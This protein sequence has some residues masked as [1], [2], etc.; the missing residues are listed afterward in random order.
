LAKAGVDV[1]LLERGEFPGAKNLFGG[2]LYSSV[3]Q[4]IVPR[5]WEEAPLER[6]I[7][8]RELTMLTEETA[9]SVAVNCQS[10]SRPPYN[11]FTILRS[12]FDR[13]FAQKA[14]EA[15]ARLVNNVTVDD[16]LVQ[17][18]R[19]TGVRT[20]RA[21]G[22]LSAKVVV[23]ADGANSFLALQA[24][25]RRQ[26]DPH[27]MVVGVKEVF[28]L[29]KEVLESRFC[30]DGST[31]VANEFV[32]GLGVKGGGFLY[33]NKESVSLG[34]AVEV[35][36]IKESRQQIVEIFEKFKHHPFVSKLIKD[37]QQVEY[38]A[39]LIPEAGYKMMPKLYTNG[40]VVVGDAAGMVLAT[41]LA[42]EGMNYA[43]A[44]GMAAAE[45]IIKALKA[46]DT[47]E[48]GLAY[49]KKLLNESFVMKDLKAFQHAP[50]F[51]QNPRLHYTYVG[52]ICNL[53]E[54]VFLSDGEPRRKLLALAREEFK[55]KA[56][57]KEL[58]A[59]ARQAGKSLMW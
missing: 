7:A 42:L 26:F 47:S 12:K 22:D 19:V 27:H 3:L 31:G 1:V 5:F 33:T 40:M 18:G 58:L 11:G 49:Y 38:G 50:A 57:W 55:G 2:A 9:V 46:G 6:V 39:H 17:N 24:G 34:I 54:K 29:P 44:G 28:R 13:W 56:T 23:A 14:V 10:Y 45:A 36:S 51:V 21:G 41:G 8:R 48:F 43:M 32:G 37:G 52:A 15:G 16:L 35:A 25:L 20:R 30:L 53:A 4:Q 59:D